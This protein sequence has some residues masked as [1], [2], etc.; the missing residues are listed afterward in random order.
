MG[1]FIAFIGPLELK[2]RNDFYLSLVK[3]I[4]GQLLSAKAAA[5]IFS[6]F[7]ML[8]NSLVSPE[9]VLMLSDEALRGIS[10]SYQK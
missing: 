4:I 10:I 2:K 9:R 1:K 3:S 8:T 6:R 7:V 5:T